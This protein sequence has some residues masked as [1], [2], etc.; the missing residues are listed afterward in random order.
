MKHCIHRRPP[1]DPP[2]TPLEQYVRRIE[3]QLDEQ[4]I[5]VDAQQ[6]GRM[7]CGDPD[8][9]LPEL[10]YPLINSNREIVFNKGNVFVLR[11]KC[12]PS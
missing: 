2:A 10:R 1:V 12:D 8:I 7:S 11:H 9:P 4:G 5:N 3:A 6:G